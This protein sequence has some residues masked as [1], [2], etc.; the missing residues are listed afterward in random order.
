MRPACSTTKMRP[1]PSRALAITTG[2]L[3]DGA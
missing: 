3:K 2:K 1:D